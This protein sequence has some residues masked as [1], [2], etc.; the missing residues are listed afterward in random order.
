MIE[1][2]MSAVAPFLLGAALAGSPADAPFV[3]RGVVLDPSRAP[4]AGARVTAVPEAGGP[5][6]STQSDGRGAFALALAPGRYVV[7]VTAPGFHETRQGFDATAA[8]AESRDFVLEVPSFRDTVT[9][10]APSGYQVAD[11]SSATR[12]LT[13]LRDVPQAVTVATRELMRDQLMMGMGDVLRYVPGVAVH[14]GENNRDQVIIR[15]NSSSADFFLDG[16]RDDV[17]YYRDLYNLERVEALKGPTAMVFGRG[18]GGG[19]INRVRKEAVFSPLSELTVQGGA[20]GHRRA[21]VDLDRPLS[22]EVALRVNGMYESSDSF[23]RAV[24]LER[25]AFNPTLTFAPGART[26]MT[27]GYEHLHDTRVADRGIPSFQGRPAG[28]DASTFFGDPGQSHV[29]ARVDLGSATVEHHAGSLTLRNRTLFGDYDR[30]YQNFVPGAVT[31]DQSRVALSAYNNATARRNVFN[32]TDVV[33]SAATGPVRHTL[34]AGVEIGAQSTDN[35]RHTGFFGAGTSTSVPYADPTVE[36]PV[37]FRPSATDADNHLRA[38]VA[39]AYA[40]DQ[41]ELSPSLRLVAGLRFDRFGLRY[42]N[43]RTGETLE[44]IDRLVSPRAGVI[45]KP[46]EPLSLYASYSVSYLPS[47]GDQFSSLTAV[48][49]EMQPEKFTGYEIG[50]KWDVWPDLSLTTAVYRLDRTNTRATD[51]N[52]PTRIVQTGAQRTSGY[53]L[54]VNGRLTRAWRVAGGYAYQDAFVTSATASARAGAQVGQVPHHTLSL[55]NHYQFH[56][57]AA[58]AIGILHRTDMYAAV[59]DT[60]TLPGYVRVDAAAYVMLRRT[61]RLQAN[62]E[63]VFDKRYHVNADGNTNISPGSP[64]SVRLALTTG[65]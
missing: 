56:P 16:V 62:L 19:V 57:R 18:G 58:A 7:A 26:R 25:Y 51:P 14:Q 28:V 24:G 32:Q 45:V 64:R 41:V 6:R 29:R 12:T 52:D 48:T 1:M 63:N 50:A 40:Q 47:A 53:E 59:D 2:M 3:L 54:G 10:S 11:I 39:A 23:R 37:S 21:A 46:A 55:W 43:N 13:P 60:V 36:L 31:A 27:L 15:G 44:R 30:F 33:Y 49:K 8:G 61:L 20:Y 38:R 42:H 35:L 5:A 34:L 22:G 9:V 4:V 17:Q 65:F